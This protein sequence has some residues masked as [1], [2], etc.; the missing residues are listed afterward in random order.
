MK[1][2]FF[3][4]IFLTFFIACK[5]TTEPAVIPSVCDGVAKSFSNDVYP[6]IKSKCKLC[7]FQYSGYSQIASAVSSIRSRVEDGSM[8]IGSSLST[9]QK[10]IIICWIDNGALNN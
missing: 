2:L 3:L 1:R 4:L 5:K 10:N 7:H 9:S 8:P 6:I